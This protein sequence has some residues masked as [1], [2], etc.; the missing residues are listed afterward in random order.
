VLGP[1]SVASLEERYRRTAAGPDDPLERWWNWTVVVRRGELASSAIGTVETT[2]L[3]REDR[4]L[5]AYSFGRDAWGSGYAF[6][7]C[8]AAIAYV[9]RAT[10]MSGIAAFIDTRNAK[11]IALAERLG[12]ER[13]ETIV[14]ADRFKG[15][16]S[17]EY[18]Y[19]CTIR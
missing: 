7:A 18:F 4:V 13:K 1:A 9:R 16:P 2:L 17:H 12:L 10:A 5:I 3:L 6:E 8:A 11:S 19:W 15:L 14:N